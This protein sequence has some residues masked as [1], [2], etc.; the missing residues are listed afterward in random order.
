MEPICQGCSAP[1]SE[2]DSYCVIEY[3]TKSEGYESRPQP[4]PA[5]CELCM[6]KMIFL[7]ERDNLHSQMDEEG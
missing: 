7:L 3:H 5:Y 2:L 4:G 6:S 1:L